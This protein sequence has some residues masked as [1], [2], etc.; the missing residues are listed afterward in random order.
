MLRKCEH[1]CRSLIFFV[2]GP[3]GIEEICISSIGRS[4]IVSFVFESEPQEYEHHP[5]ITYHH[6][7]GL[8]LM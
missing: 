8:M 3:I 5:I 7:L 6:D 4:W 1:C 2:K